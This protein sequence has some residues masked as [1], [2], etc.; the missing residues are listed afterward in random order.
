MF[1]PS[2][3]V[4]TTPRR[5]RAL[6]IVSPEWSRILVDRRA[7]R[8]HQ[9]VFELIGK[10]S[11]NRI[12]M[13]LHFRSDKRIDLLHAECRQCA[14]SK[15]PQQ[16]S[17]FRAQRAE[18]LLVRRHQRPRF[19]APT[20]RID[21]RLNGSEG[22]RDGP[23]GVLLIS[24]DYALA[25]QASDQSQNGLSNAADAAVTSLSSAGDDEDFA[26]AFDLALP[27]PAIGSLRRL[28]R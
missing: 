20:R 15:L 2:T 22:D 9:A 1:W 23:L 12:E 11:G 28:S 17:R 6:F 7:Q 5:I 21:H 27:E 16:A 10:G 8:R 13:S 3:G 26:N 25:P 24:I 14:L 19:T 4:V 18:R